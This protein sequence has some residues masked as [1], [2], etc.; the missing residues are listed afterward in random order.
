MDL[1]PTDE[2][3]SIVD[4]FGSLAERTVP[5]DR[6]RDHEPLGFAAGLWEQLV[7]VGAPGMA[8]PEA[9]G[10]ADATL[11]DLSLAVEALGRRLAPAPLIEHAVTTRLLA[12]IDRLSPQLL[13]GTRVLMQTLLDLDDSLP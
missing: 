9:A 2:Q 5:L 13:D 3:Q 8:V 7:A 11:L 10:G 1:D 12:R 6:L 4:V